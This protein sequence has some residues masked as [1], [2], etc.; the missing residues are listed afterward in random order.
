MGPSIFVIQRSDYQQ[1]SLIA[2]INL[3]DKDAQCTLELDCGLVSILDT[4]DPEGKNIYDV[5]VKSKYPYSDK[6][7]L[8][9]T[10]PALS[11]VVLKPSELQKKN[12]K[13]KIS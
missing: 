8:S 6:I 5:T 4:L 12:I 1:N 9:L 13:K 2:A 3:S 7:T 11:G 10:V